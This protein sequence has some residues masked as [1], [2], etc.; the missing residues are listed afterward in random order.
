MSFL[1]STV[2]CYLGSSS[3]RLAIW[4]RYAM[5]LCMRRRRR[6]FYPYLSIK[7]F[8]RFSLTRDRF[9]ANCLYTWEETTC[10]IMMMMLMMMVGW[11]HIF[12]LISNWASLSRL[13]PLPS[14]LSRL[15]LYAIFIG[16]NSFHQRSLIHSAVHMMINIY[17]YGT[18]QKRWRNFHDICLSAS[19]QYEHMVRRLCGGVDIYRHCVRVFNFNFHVCAGKYAMY[20]KYYHRYTLV[21]ILCPTWWEMICRM[22][23]K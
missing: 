6:L 4:F 22:R 16:V 15:K 13:V 21:V 17:L 3:A 5:I 12:Q 23:T 2:C 9:R 19:Y 11:K 1:S 20:I 8:Q 14:S 10:A 18:I 7:F